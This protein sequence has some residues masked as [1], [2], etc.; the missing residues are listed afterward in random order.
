MVVYKVKIK[1]GKVTYI[2]RTILSCLT[3]V[4][5]QQTQDTYHTYQKLQQEGDQLELV[6]KNR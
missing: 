2:I 5:P 1:G 6:S 4:S 3:L